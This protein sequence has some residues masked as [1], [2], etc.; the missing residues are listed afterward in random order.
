MRKQAIHLFLAL[1]AVCTLSSGLE[2][3]SYAAK[4]HV[5][6]AFH[7]AN[8]VM[9]AGNYIV[10]QPDTMFVQQ[11]RSLDHGSAL[12]L[13]AGGTPLTASG[14]A[15]AVFHRYG[16]SAYL[17]EVWNG[18]GSGFAIKTTKEELAAREA[19]ASAKPETVVVLAEL[20]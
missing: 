8:Q 2:A 20:R 7:A 10:S 15:R 6:F 17:A 12:T 13:K 1:S 11:I 4:F 9:E 16:D 5:P 14:G 3:Q 18:N 19:L